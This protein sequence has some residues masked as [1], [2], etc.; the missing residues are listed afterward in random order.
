V[1]GAQFGD[2]AKG[3]VVDYLAGRAD[4]TVRYQGGPNAGHTV[5]PDDRTLVLHQV[6][7]GILHEGCVAIAGP[8]MVI[9]PGDL[10]AELD[11]LKRENLLRGTFWVSERAHVILPLHRA[12]DSWEER[13]RGER[14]T[15]TTL[16]GIG[17]AYMDRV[18]R[19]GLRMAELVRPTLLEQKLSLLYSAKRH[20]LSEI[21]DLPPRDQ[22]QRELEEVGRNLA[23][24][25]RAT[26]P[27]L[28]KAAREGRAILLEGA[29]SAL[30]DVDF[31]TYPFVTS[32]HP[33][34]AGALVGSGLPPQELDEVIGVSKAYATRVGAGPFPTEL[35]GSEGDELRDRGAERGATT[36]R[37][38]RVG[39]LDLVLLRYACALN[40]FTALALTKVDVL[41]GL[42]RIHVAVGYEGESSREEGDEYP[43]VLAEDLAAVR[44]RY[45]HLKG[46]PEF[47]P[48]L[49]AKLKSEGWTAL[50]RELLEF[51]RFVS[52]S[53]QVPVRLVGYGPGRE[54]MVEIPPGFSTPGRGISPWASSAL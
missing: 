15:G 42:D 10:L 19:F 24:Y 40:G 1:I 29:Q 37:P 35:S 23:S 32:S 11:S 13:L 14:A 26:E 6:P 8:G 5:K 3:K 28:W 51:V 44:P 18:G 12:Q 39:W 43:P 27:I 34:A 49:R 41:G 52:L 30:L 45:R 4:Y 22:L 2:E 46:W 38:R 47:G 33:T 48:A 53:L 17:P 9:S 25:I 50:P 31:G 21:P 54:E 16:R 20:L 36:G 7:C